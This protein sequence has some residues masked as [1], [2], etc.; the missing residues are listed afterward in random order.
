MTGETSKVELP[1][2]EIARQCM[3][4]RAVRAWQVRLVLAPAPT[5]SYRDGNGNR[6]CSDQTRPSDRQHEDQERVTG[7]VQRL[8]QSRPPP[9][10]GY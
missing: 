1:F 3:L 8:Q 6:K 4:A 2:W 10:V 7:E 9:D 5:R